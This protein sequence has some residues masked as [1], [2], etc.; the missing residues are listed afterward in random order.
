[1]KDRRRLRSSV[2]H[3][4]GEV[5]RAASQ[6]ELARLVLSQT[7][8]AIEDGSKVPRGLP[9][10][11]KKMKKSMELDAL[12]AGEGIS[13]GI[14]GDHWMALLRYLLS[15]KVVCLSSTLM[16]HLASANDAAAKAKA[17]QEEDPHPNPNARAP[18]GLVAL[19]FPQ[20]DAGSRQHRGP[21]G[22]TAAAGAARG[23]ALECACIL[24]LSHVWYDLVEAAHTRSF[25]S[26]V[27][28][29]QAP[30]PETA[31]SP[32][33][34]SGLLGTVLEALKSGWVSIDEASGALLSLQPGLLTAVCV[35]HAYAG[36]ALPA[37]RGWLHRLRSEGKLSED[38]RWQRNLE[39][40]HLLD[41]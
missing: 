3:H 20:R 16:L 24:L 7:T 18:T 14:S 27:Q 29:P 28:T 10:A 6:L 15:W 25:R 4:A 40:L 2:G 12:E 41:L 1:V 23:Q 32:E 39:W 30:P 22:P 17:G 31:L 21:R 13:G 37:Y 9:P 26:L 33:L 11:A 35:H 5:S 34:R 8:Q 19:L 36:E 38:K